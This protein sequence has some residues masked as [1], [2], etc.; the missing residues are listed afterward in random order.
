M[1]ILASVKTRCGVTLVEVIFAIGVVMIGLL[2]LVSVLPVAGQRAQSSIDLNIGSELTSAVGKEVLARDW[3]SND[4]LI[5]LGSVG[6]VN[7][8]PK[9][10]RPFCIDPMM[11]AAEPSDDASNSHADSYNADVFPFYEPNHDPLL[12]PS[13]E[14][15]VSTTGYAG[16]PRMLRVGLSDVAALIA[17]GQFETAR[18][19]VER[20]DDLNVLRPKDRSISSSLL[21]LQASNATSAVPF[22]RGAPTGQYSWIITVD[23]F[24]DTLHASMSVVVL[25]NREL[26]DT[27]PL[28]DQEPPNGNALSERLCMVAESSG[29]SGGAGGTV[30][31]LSAGNTPPNIQSNDWIMLSRT[32]DP[33]ATVPILTANHRWY[34][35]ISVDSEPEIIEPSSNTAVDGIFVSDTGA[36]ASDK[37]YRPDTT[38]WKRTVMLDGP[39]WSFSSVAFPAPTNPL[40]STENSV[41]YATLMEGVV[42]V[43]EQS[44][45]LAN[46]E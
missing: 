33:N 7:S 41:T 34:R 35:V 2:G 9:F 21:G 15:S 1:K 17:T 5:P 24:E 26:F 12:D 42:A 16:Q 40:D 31:L 39:D 8:T 29:F 30:T 36:S 22:G 10:I 18:T 4:N 43:K 3:I 11:G 19:L 27:F 28:N 37:N 44:I 13:Q 32:V 25:R 20:P 14:T 45:S 6:V 38:V 23:P 46:F